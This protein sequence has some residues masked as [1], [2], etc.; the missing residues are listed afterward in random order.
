MDKDK[1]AEQVPRSVKVELT[2]KEVEIIVYML[3]A[4]DARTDAET[5]KWAYELRKKLGNA[6]KFFK[7]KNNPTKDKYGKVMSAEEIEKAQEV[8][9]QFSQAEGGHVVPPEKA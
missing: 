2:E 8:A 9:A 3:G 5:F 7:P 6:Q 1:P 4:V